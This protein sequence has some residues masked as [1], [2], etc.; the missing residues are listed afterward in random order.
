[1]THIEQSMEPI[2]R[3]IK[4]LDVEDFKTLSTLLASQ[5]PAEI[6][7]L[8]E[9]L[10]DPKRAMLWKLLPQGITGD[11]LANLG[12][13]ARISLVD[14]IS[15]DDVVNATATLETQDLADVIET[16]PEEISDAIRE[17]LDYR[18]LRNL[19]ATL[20][21]PEDSAGRLMDTE[22]VAVRADVDLETVLRYL[23]RRESLPVHTA[24]LMVVDRKGRFQGELPISSLLTRQPDRQVLDVMSPDAERVRPDMKQRD[25]A[26][27]FR[28][29]DLISVAVVDEDEILIGRVTIDDIVDIMQEEAD[30]QILGAAGLDEAEDL[31]APV[32]PSAQR[33]ALWLGINLGTAFLAAWVIGLFEAT[34]DKVVALAILMPIVASMGGIAGSQTLTLIIR[35]LA[36]GHIS[37]S[38]TRW[39]AYKEIAIS[40]L[41]GIV[42]AL[43]VGVISY[44]WFHDVRISG[45]LGAA[46]V[47]NM[48]AAAFSG[49]VIPLLMKKSGIDPAL[50]GSVVLTTVTDVIGFMSFLG[51][52][53]IFLL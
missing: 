8:L 53:T 37:S 27:L 51:L 10:P 17:S 33:R 45:V 32:L 13:I 22:A 34:L 9:S 23:R 52:A 11:V 18:G 43:V 40:V 15:Q 48:L 19:E 20:A 47:I 41:N 16:L 4:L 30:H 39:L 24:A 28:D 14:T 44:F 42:W 21:F 7:R 6:T 2:D 38:N 36:L 31:F 12:E 1:M 29:R 50:A 35:G 49:V 46:M 25:L 3:V 26:I 5:E